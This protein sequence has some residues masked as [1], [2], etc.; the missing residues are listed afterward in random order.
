[1]GTQRERNTLVEGAV[2]LTAAAVFVKIL[3]A[4][5]RVPFQ[6]IVGD[7]G[8]YIYQQVYPVYGI[9]LS[10]ATYG[11]P[12][13][14]SKMI[15]EAA[16]DERRRQ[17]VIRSSYYVTGIFGLVLW[18]AVFFGSKWIA[19]AMGDASLQPLLQVASLSFLLLPFLTVWRGIFQGEN[20]MIP[21]ALSQTVEQAVRVGGILFFSYWL[22]GQG[23]SLYAAGAGAFAGSLAGGLAGTGI[24]LYFIRS[25]RVPVKPSQIKRSGQR[26]ELLGLF[27][28]GAIICLPGMGLILFQ[29]VDSFNLY[30]GLLQAGRGA[31]EAK[32]EKGVYDRGQPLLQL[33]TTAAVSLALAVV[34]L[35]TMASQRKQYEELDRHIQLSLKAS[36]AFGLAA[37]AGLI[38]IMDAV[39]TMLFENSSGSLVLSIFCTAVLFSSLAAVLS[40]VLQGL[41]YDG[42]PAAAFLAGIALKYIGNIVLVPAYGTAGAALSTTAALAGV[43]LMLSAALW[44]KRKSSLFIQKSAGKAVLAAAA[45]TLSLYAWR[46]V[47]DYTGWLQLDSRLAMTVLALSSTAI[48]A[49]VFIYTMIKVKLFTDEELQYL[50]FGDKLRRGKFL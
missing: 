11:F 30:E 32:G 37:A 39:N 43:V 4:V 29:L 33:G 14:V 36:F 15:A 9:A 26:R 47:A 10:L 2:I 49:F 34:P 28:K 6:N 31:W 22:I 19:D 7:I 27:I 23:A 13:V 20:N 5:Y 41:G 40:G 44:K 1:M 3:S 8:F 42:I 38:N 46:W 21:T 16:G 48:G 17:E 45:M 18:A 12:V 25:R 35:V 24:L 50:P